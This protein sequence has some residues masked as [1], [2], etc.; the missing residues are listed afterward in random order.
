MMVRE[1]PEQPY[2]VEGDPAERTD[3]PSAS[4]APTPA[5]P[6]EPGRPPSSDA[7]DVDAIEALGEA[8]VENEALGDAVSQRSLVMIAEFD[9]QRGWEL[10]GYPSCAA[11][12]SARCRHELHTARE[13]VR[14]A[15]ALAG[16]P[17]TSAAM[18]A[19]KLSQ[20]QVR[21]LTRAATAENEDDLLALAQGSSVR[22]LERMI[23]AW[24]KGSRRS[25]AERERA[26]YESR[27]LAIFPDDEGGYVLKAR[28]TPE[29]GAMMMRAIDAAGDAIFREHGSVAAT[30]AEKHREAGQRRADAI[31]LLAERALVAGFGPPADEADAPISGGRADRYQVVLHVEPET[32]AEHAPL[33]GAEPGIG[34]NSMS[35]LEDGTRVTHETSRRLS[36]D[37]QVVE[38]EQTPDGT[39]LDVGR[40]T[41]TIPWR[42]R[43][44]LEI[45]DRGC[46]F[47]GCGRRFTDAHHVKH[48][49]N[50]GETS[51]DNCLLLCHYHHRLVH[52]GRWTIGFDDRRCPIFF[53]PRGH[54][55]YEGRWQPPTITKAAIA[56]RVRSAGP[57]VGE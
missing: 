36:C 1:T 20:C 24:R 7:R 39:V 23:R 26:I 50:G 11:W 31:A 22:E 29:Q 43:R 17:L 34:E 55:V 57:G 51:L 27:T 9:R 28:L 48:W 3:E 52:E 42:L 2:G 12:L 33:A 13:K 6:A 54:M 21:A 8:I 25:E 38:V 47:P 16:L 35:E 40:R 4:V 10:A 53:D 44:A 18:A 14:A 37:A 49:A 32:L 15:R 46:R 41:R 45:R 19:G 56:A 5:S 30:D